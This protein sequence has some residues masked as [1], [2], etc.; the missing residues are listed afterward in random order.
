MMLMMM[1]MRMN[2]DDEY[3]NDNDDYDGDDDCDDDVHYKTT[4]LCIVTRFVLISCHGNRENINVC[5]I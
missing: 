1:M 5:L 4:R 3:D 2:N